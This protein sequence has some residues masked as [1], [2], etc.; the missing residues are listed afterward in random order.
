M[1][2]RE[3]VCF[4][5]ERGSVNSALGTC[6]ESGG[7]CWMKEG[8]HRGGTNKLVKQP[9]NYMGKEELEGNDNFR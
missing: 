7:G 1:R 3:F 8:E 6:W 2:R 9:K 5:Y 4:A